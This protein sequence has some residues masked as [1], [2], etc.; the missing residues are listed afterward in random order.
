MA[1]PTIHNPALVLDW[2]RFC[3]DTIV[4]FVKMQADALREITP[5]RPV[6]TNLRALR[7]YIFIE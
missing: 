2:N 7:L 5:E 3:S 6:T 4:Q 1:A